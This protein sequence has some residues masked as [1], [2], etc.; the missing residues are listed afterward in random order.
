MA[1]LMT[2]VAAGST[3]ARQMQQNVYGAQYDKANIAADAQKKQLDLQQEQA[4]IEKTKLSN[5]VTETGFKAGEES[6]VKLQQLAL[7]PE[8]KAADD[9]G[10]LRLAAAVQLQSGDVVNGAATFNSAIAQDVK[11]IANDAKTHAANDEAIGK[12]YAA[13]SAVPDDDVPAFFDRLPEAN[14][15]AAV[16]QIGQENWDKY[17]GAQKKE[18]LKSL[19]LNTKG[20]IA[21][22]KL[23]T[24]LEKVRIQQEQANYRADLRDKRIR[25]NREDSSAFAKENRLAWKDIELAEERLDKASSKKMEA[26]DEAVD[27]A[28]SKVDKTIF[29]DKDETK[30]LTEAIKNRDTFKADLLRK[31]IKLA[32]NGPEYSG[33]K[34]YIETYK[35]ELATIVDPQEGKVKPTALPPEQTGAS[36]KAPATA[37]AATAP[38]AV[39]STKGSGDGSSAAKPLPMPSTKKDLEKGKFYQTSKG[40]ARWTG[41]G[42]STDEGT[43]PTETKRVSAAEPAP[44]SRKDDTKKLAELASGKR[45]FSQFSM[46]DLQKVADGER[47]LMTQ[48]EAKAEL[49]RRADANRLK[50]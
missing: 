24:E 12:A 16:S 2:D 27:K 26:L 7:S 37:G 20:Q 42:F 44:A 29:F 14:K 38:A 1:F 25:Q 5:L 31:K 18:V 48:E 11:K 15:K 47:G 13:I 17:T 49:K 34:D 50:E 32:E 10:K 6:K 30:A 22:Q 36:P 43:K 3:A 40:T 33:K 39:T 45:T 19:M 4:N 23:E 8:F 28:K 35:T 9:A 46:K 21:S 41:T